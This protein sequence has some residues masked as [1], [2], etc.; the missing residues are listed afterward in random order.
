MN[1][2]FIH[3][4]YAILGEIFNTVNFRYYILRKRRVSWLL[5]R[6]FSSWML[7]LLNQKPDPFALRDVETSDFV[8]ELLK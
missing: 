4:H 3:I 1:R 8:H 6:M 5:K 2:T 7:A